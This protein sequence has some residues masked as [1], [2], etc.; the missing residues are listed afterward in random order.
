[1][2]TWDFYLLPVQGEAGGTWGRICPR[3][4]DQAL[5]PPSLVCP[6]LRGR[7]ELQG[8][9]GSCP[10]Q[11]NHVLSFSDSEIIIRKGLMCGASGMSRA[12]YEFP[13]VTS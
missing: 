6:S 10:A 7:A 3:A 2:G 1:M 11:M 4:L 5:Q 9:Q 8:T 13:L 12:C